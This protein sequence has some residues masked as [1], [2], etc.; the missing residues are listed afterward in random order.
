VAVIE[1]F[2][3][4]VKKEELEG[5]RVLEVGSKYVNG[6]VRPLIERFCSPKEYIGVDIEPGKFVDLIL[7]AEKL[8]EYFGPESFDI[9]IA[10]ELLEHVQNWRL[11]VGNLKSV[12]KRG[13]YITTRSHGFPFHAY[14]YDFWRYEVEDMQK[15]FSDFEILKLIKDHEA[16]GV[17]LKAKKPFNYSPNDLQDIALFSM[18]LG[19]RTT[20]IP[21]LQEMPFSRKAALLILKVMGRTYSFVYNAAY[22]LIK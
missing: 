14:P 7:P 17:F 15:I 8:V 21:K 4:S 9:V 3:E 22:R 11:V 12:L 2:I 10:T 18:I 1:F 6:S 16:P 19:R 13:G 5:K 20:S